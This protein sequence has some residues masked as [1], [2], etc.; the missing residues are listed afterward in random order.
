M[1]RAV[2]TIGAPVVPSVGVLGLVPDRWSD[3]WQ[4]RHQVLTR[5]AQ[6]F[7]V[8]WV[9]PARG[10][11]DVLAN[12]AACSPGSTN[13]HQG[14][15]F[16]VYEP[17]LWLPKVYRPS[18][19]AKVMDRLRLER[20][21]RVLVRRGCRRIV[22]YLWRPEFAY[23]RQAVPADL[24]C[25]HIDD[26][27]SF[28]T[29]EIPTPEAEARLIASVDQVFIHSR[30][31][32]EKKGAINPHT[33]WVPN[34]VDYR[35]YARPVDEPRDLAPI[36]R[37]RIGY[38][39]HIKKQLDWALLRRLAERHPQWS[40]VFVG[41]RHEHP[42]M[43]PA[44]EEL[45]SRRNVHFLGRKS[46]EE[47]A[48]YPQHFDVCMMPYQADDYTKY[49]YPLKL[50]EYLASGRPTVGTRIRSLEDF[51]EVVALAGTLDEWSAAI[52]RALEPEAESVER[53]T[54]R[55]GVARQHDWQLLVRRIAETIARRLGSEF[56]EPCGLTETDHEDARSVA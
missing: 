11:R 5:L 12:R 42:E 30:A 32:L 41:A 33:T 24:S 17:E 55:L 52:V 34:G 13:E 44:I 54:A 18:G 50:H 38:T 19:L 40:F 8:V 46:V 26:E 3:L 31:L 37:P 1:R 20:A 51:T 22:L 21:R 9:N 49:I 36:A 16:T 2:A 25:Y 53:R 47:L 27:Y 56:V 10:W 29:V 43:L 15:G 23:A 28:S 6:Y 45:S 39:G 4:P 48:A 14:R 35:A 7:H